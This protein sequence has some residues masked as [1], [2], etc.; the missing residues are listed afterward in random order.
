VKCSVDCHI[1]L[2]AVTL[3]FSPVANTFHRIIV[4]MTDGKYRASVATNGHPVELLL[5]RH[6]TRERALGWADRHYQCLKDG[7]LTLATDGRLRRTESKA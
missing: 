5:L 4:R 1:N 6:E 3:I 7:L 2:L